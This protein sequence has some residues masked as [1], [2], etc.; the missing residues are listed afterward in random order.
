MALSTVDTNNKLVKYT[1][2]IMREYVRENM[3]SPYMS[4]ELNAIIR[5]R[6]ELMDGG[7]QMNIPLVGRFQGRGVGTGTLVGNEEKIDNYGMRVWI[8]WARNAGIIK[9]SEK[10]KDSADMWGEV[11]PLLSDWGKDRHRDD[12]I[13]AFMALP[14]ESAPTGLGSDPG[15]TVN[16]VL[17]EESTATQRNTWNVANA[18]RILYGDGVSNYNATFLTAIGNIA[19]TERMSAAILSSAKRK[20]MNSN[21]KLRPFKSKNGYDYFVAFFG[22]NTFRDLKADSTIVAANRDARAREGDGMNS[23]PIF[24]DG[25]ILYDGVICRQ[26]PEISQY[27]TDVWT[28]LTTSGGSS[29]RVEPYFFCGQQAMAFAWGRRPKPTFR[30]EDDYGFLIGNGIEMAYGVA[31]M[32]KKNTTGSPVASGSLVQWGVVTG[33]VAAPTD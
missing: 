17:F 18:D 7:E 31:K 3:F 21:P 28:L 15:M 24:Q 22:T 13:A 10:H 16:G 11:K 25:D 6:E 29:G 8:D 26:V 4:T 5:V 19:T 20:A 23:N 9:K 1:N 12:I 33:F 27:V 30:K 32:F 14:S 2:Q